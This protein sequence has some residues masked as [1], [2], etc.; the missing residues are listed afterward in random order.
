MISLVIRVV[1]AGLLILSPVLSVAADEP[2]YPAYVQAAQSLVEKASSRAADLQNF[3]DEVLIARNFIRNAEAEYKKNL[4]WTGTLDPK[5]EP[6]VRYFSAMAELQA[7]VVLSRAGKISQQQERS[8]LEGQVAELKSRIKIFDDKNAEISR[9]RDEAGRSSSSIADLTKQLASAKDENG[10]LALRVASLEADLGARTLTGSAADQKIAGQMAEI[11]SLKQ[12]VLTAGAEL[13]KARA[14]ITRLKRDVASLAAAKGAV[15][16]QSREQIE[17]LNRHKEFVSEVGSLGGVLKPGSD[18]MTVI[19]VRSAML[20][21]PKNDMLTAE[22]EKTLGKISELLKKY[23][24]YR[25]KLKV[26]GFGQPAKS[27]DAS[28]TDRMA[29]LIREALLEKGKFDP[30][31]VEALGAGSAEPIYPKSNPEG[32]KR[33]E[34]TFVKK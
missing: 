16:S 29:R 23:S 12:S 2:V 9:L 7:S 13:D 17:A 32:N 20:K 25:A 11:Q 24:E 21:S 10:R 34:V 1:L 22:G 5:A 28:A 33:V 31:A 30:A 8:R 27:E 3:T 15:E 18:T 26:H 6:T 4:S 19:F 14:E